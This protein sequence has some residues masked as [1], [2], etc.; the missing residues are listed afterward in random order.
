MRGQVTFTAGGVER[1]LQFTTN[2]LCQL[3][4]DTGKGV[5]VF[6]EAL[7]TPGGVSIKDLRLLMRAGMDGAPTLAE[8]GDVIDEIGIQAA[9]VLIGKA[10]NAAF[11]LGDVGN[12]GSGKSKAGAV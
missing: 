8:V 2:R 7:G 4:E 12:A 1:A 3:E 9:I 10:F 11:D 6:A 5:L